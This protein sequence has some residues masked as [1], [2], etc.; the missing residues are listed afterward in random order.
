MEDGSGRTPKDRKTE[1]G[2]I[3]EKRYKKHK[4]GELEIENS[5]RR[6]QIGEKDEEE[7][8]NACLQTQRHLQRAV[9]GHSGTEE[10]T[11]QALIDVT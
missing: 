6:R 7:E 9:V 4:T 3:E 2:W 8:K 5:M 1:T 11:R 10:V